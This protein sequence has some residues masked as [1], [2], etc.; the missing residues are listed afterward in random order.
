MRK[1]LFSIFLILFFFSTLCSRNS[2]AQDFMQIGLPEGTKARLG[3]GSVI[4][5]IVHLSDGM[6]LAVPSR[7]GVWTYD[8]QTG[9]ALDLIKGAY[10][11]LQHSNILQSRRTDTR[12]CQWQ[13]RLYHRLYRL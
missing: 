4:G 1:I 13:V 11:W 7:I 8:V 10:R 12:N 5:D 2:F 3:K 6:R 9:E